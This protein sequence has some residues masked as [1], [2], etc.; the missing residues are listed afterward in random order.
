M[1]NNASKINIISE[2]MRKL[3]VDVVF[4]MCGI[5]GSAQ[6]NNHLSGVVFVDSNK[7]EVFDKD[8]IVLPNVLISNGKD[9]VKTDCRGEYNI[10]KIEG[11]TVFVI[12]PSQYISK[13]NKQNSVLFYV[14]FQE[15]KEIKKYNFA[16]NPNVENENLKVVLLG[17]IQVDVIDDVH[18]VGK[19]VTEEL[20]DNDIDFIVPL[21][22][23]S[24]DNLTIFKPLSETLGLIGAPIFYSIGNHDLNFKES[25]FQDRD[26]SFE[27]IFGPSHY[28]FEYGNELF[29]VLNNIYPLDERGY[30]G[31]L[32]E[33]Q[34]EFIQQLIVSKKID[35]NRIH[36]FMHIPLEEMEDK[37]WVIQS[38]EPFENVLISAGHTHTQYHK[39]FPRKSGN[40]IHELV[41]GAVCGSWWEGPH[42]LDQVPF[43]L[44]YD[45]TPKGY[46]TV[47][48]NTEKYNYNYKVSGASS[49]KQ[50][51][52]SVPNINEWDKTLNILN[53]EYIYA[54]V[55]AADDA[56]KVF[57]SYDK[58]AWIEMSKFDGISPNVQK[59][60]VLQREGKYDS[61]KISKYPKPK[62]ISTHLWRIE[63][64]RNLNSG[65]HAIRIKAINKNIN[66]EV[67]GNAVWMN[68]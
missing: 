51:D 33:N 59:Q 49:N 39:F 57:I 24:F 47:E 18:H 44:M 46:W 22:D 61:M 5:Y 64:P 53:D 66:L 2:I 13:L 34:K 41:A 7:N 32:D 23:L 35:F 8:E 11:N 40:P 62:T 29:L 58:G 65:A 17:D 42:D 19:L 3:I 20:M 63:I 1:L 10:S 38:L 36:L 26:K 16:L 27:N 9:I 48:I 37:D 25:R 28:A 50:M 30:V 52:I 15:I 14:P 45:G 60:F 31:R 67:F 6:S 21:G 56:T 12:K 55:F 43:A 54:N 4:L 68:Y